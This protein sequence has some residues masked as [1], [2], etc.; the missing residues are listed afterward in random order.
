MASL[1]FAGKTDITKFDDPAYSFVIK[2]PFRNLEE[3]EGILQYALGASSHRML[4]L[5][6]TY[7]AVFK[8]AEETLDEQKLNAFNA[9]NGPSVHYCKKLAELTELAIKKEFMVKQ[10]THEPV[11]SSFV[12]VEFGSEY[13]HIHII[14]A[15]SG[16][17]KYN[18]KY[19][20]TSIARHFFNALHETIPRNEDTDHLKDEVFNWTISNIYRNMQLCSILTYRA[21]NG[22]KYAMRV[23]GKEFIVNYFLPKNIKYN[24]KVNPESITP[25]DQYFHMANGKTYAYTLCNGKYLRPEDRRPLYEE[26]LTSA[27]RNLSEPV[28]TGNVVNL[29]KVQSAKW[30]DVQSPSGK[31]TKKQAT[32]IDCVQTC[33]NENIITYEDL[34]SEHPEIVIMIESQPGGNRLIQQLLKMV[35]I[36]ICRQHTAL[37]YMQKLHTSTGIDVHNK[38]IQ[39]VVKQGYNPWQLGHWICCV[40]D[41]KA[42]KQNTISLYGPANTGKTNLAKA[43]INCVKLYGCVNHQNKS[44]IFNDCPEKLILWWEECKMDEQYVEQAKCLLG[45]TSFRIDKKHS[46]SVLMEQTPLIIS[47]NNDIYKVQGGN[48]TTHVHEAPLKARIVQCNFMKTLPSTFGEISTTDVASWLCACADRYTCTL[49]SFLSTW[50]IESLHHMFPLANPCPSCKQDGVLEEN[51]ICECCGHYKPLDPGPPVLEEIQPLAILGS[52]YE[53]NSHNLPEYTI[54]DAISEFNLSFL[55]PSSSLQTLEPSLQSEVDTSGASF[56]VE[57]PAKKARKEKHIEKVLFNDDWNTQPDITLQDVLWED[58][59]IQIGWEDQQH[60]KPEEDISL[61]CD[62]TLEDSD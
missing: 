16:I 45:G 23:D 55:E 22:D 21:R 30:D 31:M 36:K 42:G 1:T 56:T 62:E 28:F 33:F 18:A 13:L 14:I 60:E 32:M 49:D 7:S 5:G 38:A 54:E 25:V 53:N 41:K 3:T 2:L 11:Y 39:L 59:F 51:G 15:G 40:L 19:W 4:F 52:E 61:Y 27:V 24:T 8:E 34:V 35:H 12:Q 37:T 26:L 9:E 17:N 50:K 29:P 48:I 58:Q 10:Y 57:P 6:G 20:Q 47:T 46:E 44:F 43:I